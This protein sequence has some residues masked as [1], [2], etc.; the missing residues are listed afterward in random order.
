[1]RWEVTIIIIIIIIIII[2]SKGANPDFV[3]SPHCAA[4]H[5]QHVC[6]SGPDAIMCKSHATHR[7][8]ITCSMSWYVPS[9]TKGQ[10]SHKVWQSLNHIYFSFILWA[11][12]L[13]DEGG[14]ET[15]VPA[16]K[17]W[18]RASERKTV[19]QFQ[20]FCA[21]CMWWWLILSWSTAQQHAM[22]VSA[23]NLHLLSPWERSSR[24]IFISHPVT[25]RWPR[26][27]CWLVA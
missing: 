27:I 6:S 19:Q 5:L 26:A 4:N 14:E 15:R 21:L 16:K 17:S 12:P 13:T 24:W 25:V 9:G 22:S 10:L 8:L 18:R 2:T 7:A 23:M 11:E 1:M 3:Q 20:Y